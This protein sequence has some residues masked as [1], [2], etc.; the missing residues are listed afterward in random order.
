MAKHNVETLL[1]SLQSSETSEVKFALRLIQDNPTGDSRIREAIESLLPDRRV[2]I[3]SVK[4]VLYGELAY[5]VAEALTYEYAK[6]GIEDDVILQDT[7][8]PLQTH[9]IYEM[10]SKEEINQA[11]GELAGKMIHLLTILSAKR[12]P[13][14][15]S[16]KFFT[17]RAE[18][19]LRHEGKI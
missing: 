12:K 14:R 19:R 17:T 9:E 4:P 15:G 5:I 18:I 3:L 2:T 1:E 11:K 8:I 13:K 7:I 16:L 10:A 6:V